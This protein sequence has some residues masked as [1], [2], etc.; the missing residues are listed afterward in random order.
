[1][2]SKKP[3]AKIVQPETSSRKGWFRAGR[4]RMLE[5]SII[6]RLE[7]RSKSPLEKVRVFRAGKKIFIHAIY[8]H[9]FQTFFLW[10]KKG[11]VNAGGA[12]LGFFVRAVEPKF[13]GHG[14]GRIAL[15]THFDMARSAGLKIVKFSTSKKTS[16]LLFLSA[17][18]KVTDPKRTFQQ[19]GVKSEKELAKKLKRMN[20]QDGIIG[21]QIPKT[22]NF[23]KKLT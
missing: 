3:K 16:A 20:T 10:T 19:Y 9:G 2:P 18:M 14:L 12:S 4:K 5:K 21:D 17:G 22:I 15:E 1:M 11:L 8:E 7:Q 13:R 23:E 6:T